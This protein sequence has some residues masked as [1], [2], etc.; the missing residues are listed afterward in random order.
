MKTCLITGGSG[1]IGTHYARKLLSEGYKVINVDVKPP[2]FHSN[3]YLYI[4]H[5]VRDFSN[6]ILDE[7]VD[8][9]L[10]FAAVHTTPGHPTHEY[11]ETNVSGANEVCAF[12]ERNNIKEMVFTSSIS[13]YGPDEEQKDES[14]ELAPNSAYGYSKMLAEQ[15][16]Q[17]WLK[18]NEGAKLTIVR[19]AVVFGPGEGGNFTRLAT[20]LRK[21]GFVYPGR[22]D[23]IKSCIYV[24]DL[25]HATEQARATESR[26]ELFNGAY[27]ERYT[28][29][30]IIETFR[31]NHYPKA[32][33]IM[34]P[35][36]VVISAA[37]LLGMFNFLNIGIHPDRV[38]K[39]IK[40]TNIYPSWLVAHDVQLPGDLGS[41]L[42][43]WSDA[44]NGK[45]D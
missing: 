16:H 28:L 19:P 14:T 24:E 36:F 35:K 21:G 25:I 27:A 45:F 6:V 23:T 26:F 32:K 5:D 22:K 12:A 11:Y 2:R 1:F 39:L 20:M 7:R 3:N 30:Q 41:A 8:L 9:I 29:E 37:K 15:V 13:V 34:I 42:D 10:N 38:M 44:T 31:A 18:R 4:N 43:R 17:S 33:T 40:S